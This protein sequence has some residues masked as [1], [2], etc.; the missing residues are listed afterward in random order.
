MRFFRIIFWGILLLY[1]S[2]GY[3]QSDFVGQADRPDNGIPV[4]VSAFFPFTGDQNRDWNGTQVA[5][6]LAPQIPLNERWDTRFVVPGISGDVE[7]IAVYGPYLL[8]GGRFSYAGGVKVNN[9]AVWDG[10]TWRAIP[11]PV[12]MY[13][14]NTIF[15]D[16]NNIYFGTGAGLYVVKGLSQDPIWENL[17]PVLIKGSHS[18]IYDM[19]SYQGKIY[20]GGYFYSDLDNQYHTIAFIQG[21]SLVFLAE[22]PNSVI[23]SFATDGTVLYVGGAFSQIGADVYNDHLA[24]YDG[25]K[26]SKLPGNGRPVYSAVYSFF[27]EKD[28]LFIGSSSGMEIY[29]FGTGG[30]SIVSLSRNDNYAPSVRDIL[31]FNNE[32][33]IAGVFDRVEQTETKNIARLT[34]NGWASLS[35]ESPN[36]SVM[37]LVIYNN[38]LVAGGYFTA[39]G[40]NR[41]SRL[42]TW[43]VN[44]WSFPFD[45]GGD[46]G[47][48]GH[49]IYDVKEWNGNIYIGGAFSGNRNA[50]FRNIAYWDGNSFQPMGNGIGEYV[51]SIGHDSV[52][53]YLTGSLFPDSLG[54]RNAIVRW[55][56]SAFEPVGNGIYGFGYELLIE[57][58]YIYISYYDVSNY[59]YKVARWDGSS[60]T[61][62]GGAFN[63]RI[64]ALVMF[65]NNLYAMGM[66]SMIDNQNI[67]YLARWD[68]NQWVAVGGNPNNWISAATV[69]NGRLYVG[70]AFTNIDGVDCWYVASFDGQIWES[71]IDYMY[72]M[73]ILPVSTEADM[74]VQSGGIYFDHYFIINGRPYSIGSPD[75]TI[76]ALES[77]LKDSLL[78]V[79]GTFESIE[80]IASMIFGIY[81]INHFPNLDFQVITMDEDF[82]TYSLDISSYIQDP[83]GDAVEVTSISRFG[84]GNAV[85]NYSYQGSQIIFSSI[86]NKFGKDTLWITISDPPFIIGDTMI[87]D[88]RSVNDPPTAP[89]ITAPINPVHQ[90][91]ILFEWST[92]YDI[93]GDSV[94]YLLHLFSDTLGQDTIISDIMETSYNF[95][96]GNFFIPQVIYHTLVGA[97]DGMDTSY[98]DTLSFLYDL[99]TGI[100][101][102]TFLPKEFRLKGIYPNP[103]NPRTTFEIEI[104]EASKVE[105]QI[106]NI[107]GQRII[108][109]RRDLSPGVHRISWD[110]KDGFGQNV[111]SGIYIYR[112]VAKRMGDS[113]PTLNHSGK[114][115]YLK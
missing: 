3:S 52:S 96:G 35:G 32:I 44:G 60:W 85:V 81:R 67:S 75:K 112:V 102:R 6:A 55:N 100:N 22:E 68:G 65:Q 2:Y 20:I 27:L 42:A 76:Y 38:S 53:L 107:S 99:A 48:F 21:D 37:S 73:E 46:L 80:E 45:V 26:W 39:I 93:E 14:C 101:D 106:Y 33:I 89:I 57:N 95:N 51:Y 19:V 30:Y 87:V 66:F 86:P 11:F 110:A 97:T 28:S 105:I 62:L 17:S 12:D 8:V 56:G 84:N 77:N 114:L 5:S 47:I 49:I 7:S 98:S 41:T 113:A 23:Y 70:G 78:Y 59:T 40:Q 103:F 115:I 72:R 29:D 69:S 88:I 50:A 111:S 104:P 79:G 61:D 71:E 74:L 108:T 91:D 43:T 82:G 13:S 34:G 9:V 64:R 25:S 18:Y 4:P 31:K 63:N 36:Y 109:I 15:V 58:G 10:M 92:S 90:P 83:D 24:V 16:Q 54:P 1:S 94:V